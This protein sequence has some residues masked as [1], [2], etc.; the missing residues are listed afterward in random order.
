VNGIKN[1]RELLP[2]EHVANADNRYL[3]PLA[4]GS[5][6]IGCVDEVNGAGAKEI[7]DPAL[8]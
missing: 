1:I 8:P 7:S 4:G 5:F 2:P 3:E 6:V